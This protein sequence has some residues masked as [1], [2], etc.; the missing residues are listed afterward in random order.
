MQKLHAKT[1][2]STVGRNRCPKSPVT[3]RSVATAEMVASILL[4]Q[5]RILPCATYLQCEYNLNG[6]F[7][8]ERSQLEESANDVCKM[9]EVLHS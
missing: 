9:V 1:R 3:L 5:K 4:D 7:E 6:L 8:D 2:K